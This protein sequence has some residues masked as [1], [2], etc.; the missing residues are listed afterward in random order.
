MHRV[1]RFVLRAPLFPWVLL[2]E[3]LELVE[4]LVVLVVEVV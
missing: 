1:G 4:V 3:V 2:E